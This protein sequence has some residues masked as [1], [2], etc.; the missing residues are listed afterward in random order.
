MDILHWKQ[1]VRAIPADEEFGQPRSGKPADKVA[2]VLTGNACTDGKGRWKLD[3]KPTLSGSNVYG[4][5]SFV[6]TPSEKEKLRPVA[7]S[8]IIEGYT[9]TVGSWQ[10]GGGV[11]TGVMFAWQCVV[12]SD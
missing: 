2:V 6:A 3:L 11:A 1:S 12:L 4:R 7:L 9:V 8:V 10:L 5:P